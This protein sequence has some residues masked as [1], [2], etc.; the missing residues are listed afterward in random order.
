LAPR[1]FFALL[2]LHLSACLVVFLTGGFTFALILMIG[3]GYADLLKLIDSNPIVQFSAASAACT[4]LVLLFW[5]F[6]ARRIP[7]GLVGVLPIVEFFAAGEVA[8]RT[9]MHVA[10]KEHGADAC[11]F[12][13]RLFTFSALGTT[14]RVQLFSSPSA[15]HHHAHIVLSNGTV[16]IWSYLAMDFVEMRPGT[17]IYQSIYGRCKT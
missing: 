6:G 15:R 9:A 16:L 5:P 4:F 12:G 7:V 8:T 14:A 13:V 2:I 3:Q 1:I 11:L 10:R 17:A